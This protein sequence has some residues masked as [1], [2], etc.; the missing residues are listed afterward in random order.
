MRLLYDYVIT[1][2]VKNICNF[3]A[4]KCP[5]KKRDKTFKPRRFGDNTSYRLFLYTLKKATENTKPN[6]T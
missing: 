3:Y 1:V 6:L 5:I 2:D 4:K